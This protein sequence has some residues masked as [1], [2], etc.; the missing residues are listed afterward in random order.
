MRLPSRPVIYEINTATYLN[1]L[2][3]RLGR[4]IDLA[5]IPT[6]E[7]GRLA[8]LGFDAV[9]LMGIWKRSP[10][11]LPLAKQN[12]EL[13]TTLPDLQEAD[14]IGSAYSIQDYIVSEDFGGNTA[15]AVTRAELAKHGLGLI[16]DYVPN[17]VALDHPWAV[18]HPEY[19]IQGT[20]QALAESP[21]AFCQ[22]G[23]FVLAKGRDPNFPPWSDVLQLN[24]FS[25]SLRQAVE[26]TLIAIADQCDGVRCDMAMLLMNDVFAKTW[27]K[28]AGA[29][30]TTDYWPAIITAVREQHPNFMLMA[31]VYW[32]REAAL[33]QQGFNLCYDKKLYDLFEAGSPTQITKYLNTDTSYQRHL[34][35][36]IENHDEPRAA[37]LFP[38]PQEKA[39]AVAISTLEGAQLYHDGQFEGWR[40]RVPV[41]LRRR[42][43]EPVNEAFRTFYATLLRTI[44]ESGL[45][46][47]AWSLLECL[48]KTGK[49][50]RQV[51]AW[52]WAGRSSFHLVIINLS[53]KKASVSIK[54]I[55]QISGNPNYR[56]ND[57]LSHQTYTGVEFMLKPWQYYVLER[58]DS[59]LR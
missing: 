44:A 15:L 7:W 45:R 17:H 32:D 10:A 14:I 39:L 52:S 8:N 53:N 4:S 31:E 37:H 27:G 58:L 30:P 43:G 9:W 1:D 48:S 28:R 19:F 3:R 36:F 50:S 20:K 29:V 21:E 40:R 6:D 42:P 33:I 54:P 38:P 22:V 25:S 11:G 41:H 24:A 2:S 34:V 57:I 59:T 26:S 13:A 16:L 47:G 35:R 18:E 12:P 49:P 56:W 23:D 55:K 46:D 5:S 51:V